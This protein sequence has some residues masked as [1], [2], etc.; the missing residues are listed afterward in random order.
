MAL[1]SAHMLGYK[2]AQ[3]FNMPYLAV[4]FSDFWHRWH[5]SLS[6]WLRDYLFIPLGGSRGGPWKTCRNLLLTMTLGGLWHGVSWMF[7]LWGFLHGVFLILHRGFRAFCRARPWLDHLLQTGPGTA[8]H[9]GVT[10][11]GVCL[12]WVFFYT[13]SIEAE[14]T[15]TWVAQV[16]AGETVAASSYS[17]LHA[18]GVILQRLF[19]PHPG[20][21]IDPH[22]RGLWYT[23][24]VV[25]LA[26]A[27]AAGN[28]WKK[29]AVRLPAPVMGFG[30]AVLLTFALLLAPDTGRAFL[31][32]RF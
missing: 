32:F 16:A 3:N 10:F 29:L 2:L 13:A 14:K 18:S 11:L 19:I 4:N 23:V 28:R 1:G 15:L 17:A 20:Q 6:S 21:G 9:L 31:Y 7:V 27:L 30:Y 5:I 12:G 26:H 22:N 8:L 25:V 24:L